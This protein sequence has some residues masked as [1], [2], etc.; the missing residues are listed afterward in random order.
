[1]QIDIHRYLFKCSMFSS[2]PSVPLDHLMSLL[3]KFS[4]RVDFT[5]IKYL[6]LVP[7]Y[8]N[9]CFFCTSLPQNVGVFLAVSG[10]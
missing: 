7:G 8:L 1:M 4:P 2:D 3:P 5:K 6:A 9:Q 10:D